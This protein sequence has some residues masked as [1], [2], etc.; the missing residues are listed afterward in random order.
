MASSKHQWAIFRKGRMKI[1]AC[2]FCGELHLPSNS[3]Q[4]CQQVEIN[5]SPI[6]LAGYR[7][8]EQSFT[9]TNLRAG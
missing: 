2:V 9:S 1:K 8:Y 4:E 6:F 5:Q 3:T 7:P